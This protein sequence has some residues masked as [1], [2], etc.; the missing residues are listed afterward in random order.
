MTLRWM[1][2]MGV[3]YACLFPTP[4]LFLGTHPQP[5]V[6]VGDGAGLQPLALRAILAHE[7]RIVSMLYLPFNDPE[8]A[9]R[10]DGQ[11]VRRQEGRGRLHGDLAALQAGARQRLHED[12]RA[13]RGD[14]Q[15]D[16]VPR[17]LQL[18]RPGAA[19]TNRFIAV[20]ALGFM[21]FNMV[22]MTNWVVNGLPSASPS[23]R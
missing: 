2:A 18:G 20:H 9:Y 5:E 1:D 3:D 15:A 12:L 11:G 8:A 6:E 7:P 21:W 19:L 10:K 22:H 17:R 14:G 4:M 16:V 23:S 13:D